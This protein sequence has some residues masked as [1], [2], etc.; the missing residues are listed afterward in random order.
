MYDT[1]MQELIKTY[2]VRRDLK[3]IARQEGI[4]SQTEIDA[5]YLLCTV[6]ADQFAHDSH[7]T[8]SRD[9]LYKIS[10]TET[11]EGSVL[12]KSST[13][14]SQQLSPEDLGKFA[15]DITI[16]A[17]TVPSPEMSVLALNHLSL[18]DWQVFLHFRAFNRQK[19]IYAEILK[20]LFHEVTEAYQKE[21]S[22]EEK[23]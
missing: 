22:R 2:E 18:I 14:Q 13:T 15:H 11:L 10:K 5:L 21:K 20:R 19:S 16:T 4:F 9:Q 17:L 23:S 6:I 1:V 12:P 8:S 3:R 7:L